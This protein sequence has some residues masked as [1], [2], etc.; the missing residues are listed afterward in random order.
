MKRCFVVFGLVAVFT[1]MAI[2]AQADSIRGRVGVTGRL[3]FIVPSNSDDIATETGFIGGGGLIYGATDKIALEMDV[4]QAGYDSF[5]GIDF[6]ITDLSFGAQYRF[7]DLAPR[8]LVPYVGGGFDI[9][10]NDIDNGSVDT[11]VGVHLKGGADYFLMKELAATAE[12]KGVFAPD[13]DTSGFGGRDFDPMN[14][15]V[16]FGVR[17]FFN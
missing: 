14:F 9:L 8:Q 4:T 10:I 3:G 15:S 6:S 13:A 2:S 7:T 1:L 11:V 17:Y 5:E 16:T 12:W